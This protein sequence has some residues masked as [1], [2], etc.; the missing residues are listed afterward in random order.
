M[1]FIHNICHIYLVLVTSA[2]NISKSHKPCRRAES[3]VNA[4]R[5]NEKVCVYAIIVTNS[6]KRRTRRRHN[7]VYLI[8]KKVFPG[9]YDL[10]PSYF[11]PVHTECVFISPKRLCDGRKE[12]RFPYPLYSPTRK[13]HKSFPYLFVIH[14]VFGD[15]Y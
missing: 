6:R 2:C 7:R 9:L 13:T 8:N 1:F 5:I 10:C 15:G 4:N 11:L 14:S 12:F 3:G